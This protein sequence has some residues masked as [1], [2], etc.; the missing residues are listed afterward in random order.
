MSAEIFTLGGLI[1][2]QKFESVLDNN[3]LCTLIDN[4]HLPTHLHNLKGISLGMNPRSHIL[5]HTHT[6][7]DS[8]VM[9]TSAVSEA[10]QDVSLVAQA[11]KAARIVDT[12]VVAGPFKGALVDV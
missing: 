2:S 11:L 12:G 7:S 9:L 6:V 8:L 3:C 10:I 5:C 4:P 1:R